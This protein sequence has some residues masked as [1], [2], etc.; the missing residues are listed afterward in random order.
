MCTAVHRREDP[1]N[2]W[3]KE[4]SNN[5]HVDTYCIIDRPFGVSLPHSFVLWKLKARAVSV[6]AISWTDLDRHWAGIQSETNEIELMEWAAKKK[7][8]VRS[9]IKSNDREYGLKKSTLN[10]K[11]KKDSHRLFRTSDFLTF[12]I[13][14]TLVVDHVNTRSLS[15]YRTLRN[16]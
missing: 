10:F 4:R 9:T 8:I 11:R 1:K 15:I 13:F 16:E 5:C 12:Y 3:L 14:L 7:F 6:A 2:I